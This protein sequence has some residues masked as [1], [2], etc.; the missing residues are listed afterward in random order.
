MWKLK[1]SAWHLFVLRQYVL[2]TQKH[3]YSILVKWAQKFWNWLSL[4]DFCIIHIFERYF[5]DSCNLLKYKWYEIS[6]IYFNRFFP[7]DDL[8]YIYEKLNLNRNL[9]HTHE[10]PSFVSKLSIL[11]FKAPTRIYMKF[12]TVQTVCCRV[13]HCPTDEKKNL[14]WPIANKFWYWHC[15]IVLNCNAWSNYLSALNLAW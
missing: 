10:F 4:L 5:E 11:H 8:Y 1:W 7:L 3:R 14:Q 12:N 9:V 6:D 2:T 13:L 15:I